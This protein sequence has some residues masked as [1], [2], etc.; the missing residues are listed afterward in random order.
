M[1]LVWFIVYMFIA[2][3]IGLRFH[4]GHL[5]AFILGIIAG[6]MSQLTYNLLHVK[7]DI[8]A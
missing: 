3:N 6:A 5:E 8:D 4:L 2:I 7:E 1:K